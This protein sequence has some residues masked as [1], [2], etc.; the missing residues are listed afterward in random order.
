LVSIL[1]GIMRPS[2]AKPK[3]VK[4][5]ADLAFKRVKAFL[6]RQGARAVLKSK[7]SFERRYRED[8]HLRKVV[9]DINI[10]EQQVEKARGAR[11]NL[12]NLISELFVGPKQVI[13]GD[14]KI[15]VE[16]SSGHE[17]GLASLSSGEK[18]L[19][20]LLIEALLAAESSL[21]VDEPEISLHIDWQRRL[22]SAMRLLNPNAQFI[23]ATHAPEIMADI[24]DDHIFRL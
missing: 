14:T 9:D 13:F 20:R 18:Q 21:L 23:F 1:R 17:I 5:D 16:G 24:S 7:E 11:N 22:V 2:K 3:V 4:F 12:E 6:S 19:L 8:R 10:V 15:T